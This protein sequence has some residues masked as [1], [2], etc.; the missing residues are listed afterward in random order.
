[1]KTEIM[2]DANGNILSERESKMFMNFQ[3]RFNKIKEM[4][5]SDDKKLTNKDRK[6]YNE[7]KGSIWDTNPL[8]FKENI[9]EE[10]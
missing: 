10:K 3:E 4:V 7:Y 1:M 8:F 6:F 9:K 2:K 5:K